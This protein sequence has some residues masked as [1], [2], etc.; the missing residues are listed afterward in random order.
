MNKTESIAIFIERLSAYDLT[1]SKINN[2]P[3]DGVPSN[4]YDRIMNEESL[5][6]TF[7][8]DNQP[9][10]IKIAVDEETALVIYD[11]HEV[12]DEIAEDIRHYHSFVD[13]DQE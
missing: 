5:D 11:Y 1:I 2:E 3:C 10:S 4:L 7:D 9:Y 12:F 6:I 13:D 8:I